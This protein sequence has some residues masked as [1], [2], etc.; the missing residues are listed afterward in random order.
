MKKKLIALLAGA[1][2]TTAMAGNALA[3]FADFDL[4][5]VVYQRSGGTVEVG[6][7][8]GKLSDALKART[9]GRG[10]VPPRPVR[11]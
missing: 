6:T 3:A 10:V 11:R 2:L 8:T 4:I 5:R 9:G 1:L 7:W